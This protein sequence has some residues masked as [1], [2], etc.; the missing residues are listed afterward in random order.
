MARIS[1]PPE[2]RRQELIETA[3]AL[4]ME[5]GYEQTTVGDIVKRIGVAQGLFYYYFRSK[6]DIFLALVD[7]IIEQ[8]IGDIAFFLRDMQVSPL[9]R[10]RNVLQ[11]LSGSLHGME[12]LSLRSQAGMAQELYAIMQNHVCE[13]IEPVITDLLK[14]GNEQGLL[15]APYPDRLARLLISGFIGMASMPN[16]PKAEEMMELILFALEKLLSVPKR[17]LDQ[18]E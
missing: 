10:I 9:D 1:K 7:Q 5:Q 3:K 12:V 11:M 8:N 6:Q 17:A 15:L 14:E 2:E 4:F 16:P 13:V 18:G